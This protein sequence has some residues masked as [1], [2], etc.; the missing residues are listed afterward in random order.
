MH[1]SE[2]DAHYP[3]TSYFRKNLLV[4]TLGDSQD[5]LLLGAGSK[6]SGYL[7]YPTDS[8]SS[9]DGVGSFYHADK[10]NSC[11]S[12]LLLSCSSSI[13]HI[14][15]PQNPTVV[16]HRPSFLP[17]LLCAFDSYILQMNNFFPEHVLSDVLPPLLLT[18]LFPATTTHIP[19]ASHN[20]SWTAVPIPGHN[21][22]PL[23][24]LLLSQWYKTSAQP[25]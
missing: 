7:D 8:H 21:L 22:L 5:L 12:L 2:I 25:H 6:I 17:L 18:Y 11:S 3:S 9:F 4:H 15:H 24:P 16:H 1:S 20:Q 23:L 19:C 10:P 13:L 14:P